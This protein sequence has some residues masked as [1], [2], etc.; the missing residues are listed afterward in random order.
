MIDDLIQEIEDKGL[1]EDLLMGTVAEARP[2]R[3]R[4]EIDRLTYIQ[5]HGVR[6]LD[7]KYNIYL[8]SST[9]VEYMRDEAVVLSELMCL[10]NICSGKNRVEHNYGQQYLLHR[11]LKLFGEK[12]Y[13]AIVKEMSQLDDR[14]CLKPILVN[15][16]TE[17]EKRKAQVALAYLTEKR[18]GAIKGKNRTAPR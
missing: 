3:T 17:S 8:Q 9:H 14:E 10:F 11:G 2:S 6:E 12:G 16:M 18:D 15:E 13:E 1:P 4:R 5:V 7:K